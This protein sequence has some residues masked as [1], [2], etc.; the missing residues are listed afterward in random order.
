MPSSVDELAKC[1]TIYVD[2]PGWKEDITKCTTFKDLP[3]AAQ[4]YLTFCE[5]QTGV[6]ISW[7]GTGPKREEMFHR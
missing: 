2:L 7:V 1:K 4:D 5:E 3:R 6:P